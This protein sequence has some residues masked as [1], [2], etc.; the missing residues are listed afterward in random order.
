MRSWIRRRYPG[1]DYD[2]RRNRMRELGSYSRYKYGRHSRRRKTVRRR[3][4]RVRVHKYKL[5]FAGIW[6]TWSGNEA[7]AFFP[8]LHAAGSAF[9]NET[10]YEYYKNKRLKIHFFPKHSAEQPE[11]TSANTAAQMWIHRLYNGIIPNDYV[12]SDIRA[13]EY[14]D[15]ELVYMSGPKT[16]Y[17][18]K[19]GA[20]GFILTEPVQA[21]PS[22]DATTYCRVSMSNRKYY[23]FA[24]KLDFHPFMISFDNKVSHDNDFYWSVWIHCKNFVSKSST[25][26]S[27]PA[28][29]LQ[30]YFQL[31]MV[32]LE[33]LKTKKDEN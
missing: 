20:R 27:G 11:A 6:P 29:R 9:D 13:D 17:T 22:P 25:I 12:H 23:T 5:R 14:E 28:K 33:D 30:D 2:P 3:G 10:T 26:P 1:L 21:D 7:K 15:G 19:F 31:S 18:S 16:F 24:D 8:R 32:S 4:T